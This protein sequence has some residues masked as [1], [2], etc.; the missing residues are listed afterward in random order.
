MTRQPNSK[1]KTFQIVVKARDENERV[2]IQGFKELCMRD[3]LVMND[4]LMDKIGE[5]LKSHHWPPGNPQMQLLT[6]EKK[7]GACRF[8]LRERRG[9]VWCGKRRFWMFPSECEKCLKA[10]GS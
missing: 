9:Q 1:S 2:R 5:V 3:G 4:V 10:E 7:V 8:A 6:A